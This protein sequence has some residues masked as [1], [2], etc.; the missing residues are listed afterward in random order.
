MLE[1]ALL[2]QEIQAAEDREVAKRWPSLSPKAE[3]PQK[4]VVVEPSRGFTATFCTA[5][6]MAPGISQRGD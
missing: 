2:A 4:T 3:E 1:D 5:G 6:T